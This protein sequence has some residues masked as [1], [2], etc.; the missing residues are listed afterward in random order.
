MIL[1]STNKH[2][3]QASS[4]LFYVDLKILFTVEWIL[5]DLI[6]AFLEPL[7]QLHEFVVS[8]MGFQVMLHQLAFLNYFYS[9]N[10]ILDTYLQLDESYTTYLKLI[11]IFPTR[12]LRPHWKNMFFFFKL[13]LILPVR[14]LV[15]KHDTHICLKCVIVNSNLPIHLR[16]GDWFCVYLTTQ[17]VLKMTKF[18]KHSIIVVYLI[19]TRV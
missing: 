6:N 8:R 13:L 7:Y 12:K 9:T 19:M 3:K 14:K 18:K 17:R 16:K 5:S 15:I 10:R 1:V 4:R 2:I 11:T